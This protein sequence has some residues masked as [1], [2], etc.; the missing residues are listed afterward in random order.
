MFCHAKNNIM[1]KKRCFCFFILLISHAYLFSVLACISELDNLINNNKKIR[2][3]LNGYRRKIE[4]ARDYEN[5][6]GS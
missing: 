4:T 1:F 2:P 5:K 6:Q 3:I